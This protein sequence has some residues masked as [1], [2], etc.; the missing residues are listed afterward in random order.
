MERN[1]VSLEIF[2]DEDQK[3]AEE[4]G[5]IGVPTFFFI[6]KN[7]VTQAVEHRLLENYEEILLKS[8]RV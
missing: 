3:L 6:N 2:L 7:G 4:Y 1:K 5:L 8:L